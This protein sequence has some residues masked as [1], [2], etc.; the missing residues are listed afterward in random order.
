MSMAL[1]EEAIGYRPE[2]IVAHRDPPRADLL[3]A[4]FRQHGWRVRLAGSGREAR[5][6]AADLDAPTVLLSTEQDEESGWLTCAKL[7]LERP[8]ARVFLLAPAVTSEGRRYAAFVGAAGLVGDRD[9]LHSLVK[10]VC[11]LRMPVAG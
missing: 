6:L 7:R 2:L 8:R 9:D 10:A 1:P 4:V 3:A 5:A 11:G